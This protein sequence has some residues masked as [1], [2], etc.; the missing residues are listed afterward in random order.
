MA[1]GT[2]DDAVSSVVGTVLMLTITMAVFAGFAVVV[3]DAFSE[4]PPAPRAD[5]RVISGDG[6]TYVQHLGGSPLSLTD[7]RLSVNVA[8]SQ[9]TVDA[10]ELEARLGPSWDI[11][12][13]LCVSCLYTGAE[14]R[15]VRILTATHLVLDHGAPGTDA[16]LGPDLT[17]DYLGAT[18]AFPDEAQDT[19]LLARVHNAGAADVPDVAFDVS[20]FVDGT[21]VA[22]ETVSGPVAVDGS[23]DVTSSVWTAQPGTHDIVVTVDAGDTVA[24]SEEGNNDDAGILFVASGQADPGHPYEDTDF[25]GLY[26]DGVDIAL[27]A[28][29]VTDG[30]HDAG[31]NALVVPPSTGAITADTID[32]RGQG[33]T[34]RVDLTATTNQG[35]TL[36]STAGIDATA[37]GAGPTFTSAHNAAGILLTSGG[38]IDV[39]GTSFSS[40]KDLTFDLQQSDRTLFLDQASLDD[41]DDTALVAPS[42]T[43]VVGTPAFGG[44]SY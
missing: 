41:Q 3:L 24:E 26:Q 9:D 37:S 39:Q 15:G 35:I 4:A 40:Q 13:S 21:L 36:T 7:A 2:R 17:I 25:D 19:R 30:I 18:P 5:I 34:V 32:F 31:A 33:I 28:A 23:V 44:W 11:G 12:E 14:I 20:F 38:D 29:Q 16:P 1:G 43:A 27:T 22:T 8:G 42:G 10:A 6:G